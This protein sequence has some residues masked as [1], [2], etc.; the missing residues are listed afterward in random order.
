MKTKALLF[1]ILCMFSYIGLF[2]QLNNNFKY[3]LSRNTISNEYNFL[4]V[5]ALSGYGVTLNY[6]KLLLKQSHYYIYGKIGVGYGAIGGNDISITGMQLPIS[7]NI[8]NGASNNHFEVNLGARTFFDIPFDK[9]NSNVDH[10]FFIYPIVNLG[11]RYQQPNGKFLFKVL[12]GTDG[13]SVGI[14]MTF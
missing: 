4:Y 9:V 6:E 12:G 2:G 13:I 1:L 14:G 5:L 8:L 11:Y 7:L 10:G 3:Q